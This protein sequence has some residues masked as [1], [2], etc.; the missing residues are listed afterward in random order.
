MIN[1]RR[2]RITSK[3]SEESTALGIEEYRTQSSEILYLASIYI[4]E[5]L[6]LYDSLR[7]GIEHIRDFAGDD[8]D[9]F[10]KMPNYRLNMARVTEGFERLRLRGEDARG[11]G[12]TQE[13]AEDALRRKSSITEVLE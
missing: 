11:L 10:V 1:E 13:L 4:P 12:H 8:C 5:R 9:I 3:V 2:F 7:L 6:I